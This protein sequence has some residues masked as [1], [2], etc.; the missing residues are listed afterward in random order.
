VKAKTASPAVIT[1]SVAASIRS[2]SRRANRNGIRYI[3]KAAASAGSGDVLSA[4]ATAAL[5]TITASTARG[6]RRR[7]AAGS[8]ESA[9]ITAA[10]H[11]GM[12]CR[13]AG[14]WKAI[15]YTTVSR[16]V[17]ATSTA[18][19]CA[20]STCFNSGG[21]SE[22]MDRRYLRRPPGRVRPGTDAACGT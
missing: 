5:V 10:A 15:P 11:C 22:F 1:S 9:T 13:S 2:A 6:Q 7:H 8:T 18:T 17:I 21:R 14:S 4:V 20:D 12:A 3:T 19:W 16:T